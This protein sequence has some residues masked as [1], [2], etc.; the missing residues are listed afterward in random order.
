MIKTVSGG[1]VL[2][3]ALVALAVGTREQWLPW[4]ETAVTPRI[5]STL[6]E[7]TRRT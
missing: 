2:G 4:F 3:V 7:I 1:L 6:G 5:S